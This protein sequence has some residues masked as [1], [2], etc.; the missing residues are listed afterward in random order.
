M[1][2]GFHRVLFGRAA[3]SFANCPGV[4]MLPRESRSSLYTLEKILAS[5]FIIT[6]KNLEMRAE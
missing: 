2:F 6:L 4:G 5:R 3:D 1:V